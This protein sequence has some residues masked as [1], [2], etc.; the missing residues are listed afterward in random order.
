M[1]GNGCFRGGKCSINQTNVGAREFSNP[2]RVPFQTEGKEPSADRCTERMTQPPADSSASVTKV[3]PGAAFVP[4]QLRD[5]FPVPEEAAS[6]TS[7]FTRCIRWK[8]KGKRVHLTWLRRSQN[9]QLR[10]QAPESA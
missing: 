3:V 8:Q 2:E 6:M 1:D 5:F 9:Q 10:A 4:G 7:S